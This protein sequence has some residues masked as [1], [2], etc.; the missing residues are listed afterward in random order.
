MTDETNATQ[1]FDLP[2][3]KMKMASDQNSEAMST[4]AKVAGVYFR[5]LLAQGF[6]REEAHRLVEQWQDAILDYVRPK[7]SA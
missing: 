3:M 4:F 7:H 5:E 6:E 2:S 1:P